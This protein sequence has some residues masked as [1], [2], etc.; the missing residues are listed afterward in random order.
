MWLSDIGAARP[1]LKRSDHVFEEALPGQRHSDLRDA[2]DVGTEGRLWEAPLSGVPLPDVQGLARDEPR[3]PLTGRG[4]TLVRETSNRKGE[5][6]MLWD[7][8]KPMPSV[9]HAMS[10]CGHGGARLV[11]WVGPTKAGQS[12]HNHWIVMSTMTD[13]ACDV[14]S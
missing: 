3:R 7:W 8:V 6:A 1:I 14:A 11:Y 2:Q 4:I 9:K 13:V 5:A 12:G 10:P